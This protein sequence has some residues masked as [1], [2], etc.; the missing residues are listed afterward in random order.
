VLLE[1]N[2]P[3]AFSAAVPERIAYITPQSTIRTV[4]VANIASYLVHGQRLTKNGKTQ[5]SYKRMQLF[6][7][8]FR[9]LASEQLIGQLTTNSAVYQWNYKCFH[10][11][12][13]SHKMTAIYD[14][15]QNVIH[16]SLM[17]FSQQNILLPNQS[18]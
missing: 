2:T 16:L 9:N 12:H 1:I 18:S 8:Y 6:N 11:W 5:K 4:F 7:V 17:K 13:G 10:P 15:V 3:T 14:A